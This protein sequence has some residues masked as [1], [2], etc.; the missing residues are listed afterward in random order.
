M[1]MF[2]FV[3]VGM[4]IGLILVEVVSV[5]LLNVFVWLF[6]LVGYCSGIGFVWIDFDSLLKCVFV[7]VIEYVMVNVG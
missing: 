5:L 6:D 3:V 1:M 7:D 4:G 2:V